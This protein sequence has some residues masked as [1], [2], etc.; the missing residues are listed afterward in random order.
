MSGPRDCRVVGC[1]RIVEADLWDAEYLDLLRPATL[2]IGSDGHG[3]IAFGAFQAGL[4]ISY[5]KTVAFFTWSGFD[6]MDEVTGDGS[7]KLL[8]DGSLEIE[9]NRHLG[10]EAIPKAVSTTSS[11]AC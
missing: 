8:D 11:T 7:A 9:F 5:G 1:W 6:E 3:E 10:D 2:I 4:D